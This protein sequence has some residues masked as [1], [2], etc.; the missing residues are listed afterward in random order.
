MNHTE[1]NFHTEVAS[2][3]YDYKETTSNTLN[4]M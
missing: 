3:F 2:K 4:K 1:N